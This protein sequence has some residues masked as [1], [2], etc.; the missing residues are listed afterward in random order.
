MSC[1]WKLDI[2]ICDNKE[3]NVINWMCV[4]SCFMHCV[5]IYIRKFKIVPYNDSHLDMELRT[6]PKGMIQID[7]ENRPTGGF[8]SKGSRVTE[9]PIIH[10]AIPIDKLNA[11]FDAGG[12]SMVVGMIENL[13]NAFYEKVMSYE[14][15]SEDDN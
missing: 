5:E 12:D 6:V 14:E 1:P 3:D 11:F 10:D 7:H 9:P 4:V 13:V 8:K 15:E 2:D